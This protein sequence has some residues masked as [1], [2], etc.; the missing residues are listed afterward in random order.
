[1]PD[2]GSGEQV[3]ATPHP[4][5][6]GISPTIGW[7]FRPRAKGG[8]A[9]MIIRRSALGSLKAVE[10]FPLTEQGW[11]S[12]WQSLIK[13]DP[14][15]AAK[16][17]AALE[18]RAADAARLRAVEAVM[19]SSRGG[20]DLY[21]GSLITLYKVAFLGGYVQ[22]SEIVAGQ[23]YDVPFFEDRLLVIAYRRAEVL[24]E[25][26][27]SEI[28]DFE[29]GGPGLVKTGGGFVGGGIGVSGAAQGMAV[30]AVLNGLTTRTS[31]KTV[32]RV[33][34]THCELFL[35]HSRLTPEQLRIELSRPLGAIRSARAA[36]AAGGIQHGAPARSAAP[37]EELT[38][39]ADMLERG[40]LT[41]EEFNLMKA[42]LLGNHT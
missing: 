26:P 17:L 8:P 15:A 24:A 9:F 6:D 29:I 42:K 39:L 33:Q 7:H 41:R 25:V 21:T 3:A 30:A 13:Q 34:G 5:V 18:A 38:K 4:L 31:V 32:V 14:S 40:L 35:L 23:R 1:M 37:V 19:P 2:I 10:T 20:S 36:D 28:E 11:V 22:G 27:Y 16:I 12:A